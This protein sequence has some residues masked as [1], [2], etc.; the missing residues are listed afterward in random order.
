MLRYP[1]Y[2]IVLAATLTAVGC[3]NVRPPVEVRQDPYAGN[4][5]QV[6]DERLAR[7]L[8]F[9]GPR[10]SRDQAGNLLFVTIPVRNATS[11]PLAVEYRVS[12]LDVNGQP[13]PGSPT[14]WFAK[15]LPANVFEQ[16]TVNS[17]SP[18]AADFQVDFRYAR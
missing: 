10:V 12:F 13:L 14:T 4:Q 7:A 5:I 15:P 18:R 8:A 1:A 6:A 2:L 17:V 9:G 11:G 16:V 3:N